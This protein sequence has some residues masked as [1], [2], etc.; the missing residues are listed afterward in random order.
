M[1]NK[2]TWGLFAFFAI[3]VGLYPLLF[4]V[5]D[6]S[7]GLLST[8]P[9]EVVNNSLYQFIFHQHIYMGGLALLVGWS[10]FSS[11]IRNRF[12]GL[13]RALGK[14]YLIAVLLSGTAGLYIAFFATGGIIPI[15]GFSILAVIWLYSSTAA[16]LAIRNRDID[17]HQEWMIRSYA[18][19]FGAVTFRI[20]GPL[21]QFG[22]DMEFIPAYKI[23]SWAAWILNLSVAE[24]I[25]R[26]KR[27]AAVVA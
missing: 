26:N 10:Q 13:H 14:T 8:K 7:K 16:Y 9:E 17:R 4:L 27:R 5:M 6:M 18:L 1:I 22:F 23:I 15:S 19:C 3:G 20:M 2:L 11:K 25:I 24:V 12:L 21:L